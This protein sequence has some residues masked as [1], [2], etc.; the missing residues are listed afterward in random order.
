[1]GTARNRHRFWALFFCLLGLGSA[2]GTVDPGEVTLARP[3]R[4]PD[5]VRFAAFVH[6]ALT[7][8]SGCAATECH[9]RS[10]LFPLHTADALPSDSEIAHPLDL[11]EPF[12]SDYYTVLS[13]VN[14]DN[15]TASVLFRW[16]DGDEAEHP[17][18]DALDAESRQMLLDWLAGVGP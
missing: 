11:P 1:M 12:R 9:A 4:L 15:P 3:Q 8:D 5:P 18:G 17:G 6:P 10:A 7:Q 13:R 14:F 2:C 16:A